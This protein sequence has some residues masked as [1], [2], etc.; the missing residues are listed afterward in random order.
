MK[1]VILVIAFFT[2]LHNLTAQ[3]P[4]YKWAYSIGDVSQEYLNTL[5]VDSENNI[6]IG[7][8]MYSTTDMDPTEFLKILNQIGQKD[9]FIEKFDADGHVLWGLNFG[10]ALYDGVVK[11]VTDDA[12]NIYAVGFYRGVTDLNPDM[13]DQDIAPAHGGYDMFI[14][15]FNKE[16]QF[17]W[18]HGI[19]GLKD[20]FIN[21][22]ALD[23]VGNFYITGQ[24]N[25]TVDFDGTDAGL[26]E[27]N[28]TLDTYDGFLAKYNTDGEIS[29][30]FRIGGLYDDYTNE[31]AI[32]HDGNIIVTGTFEGSVNFGE[33]FL[34]A[35]GGELPGYP[36]EGDAF[37]AKY[38]NSGDL[39]WA[40]S[41]AG[42]TKSN[43]GYDN[44]VTALVLDSEDNI[45][46]TGLIYGQGDFDMDEGQQLVST[47]AD[48]DSYFSKYN[49]EGEYIWAH[50]TAP[51][52]TGYTKD[53]SI[54]GDNNLYLTG[55][56]HYSAGAPFEADFDFNPDSVYAL[57]SYGNHD[58]FV[59]KYAPDAELFWAYNIGGSG[60]DFS[61][62]IA[63][64]QNQNIYAGGW[65]YASDDFDAN[66][67]TNFIWLPYTYPN[68]GDNIWIGKYQPQDVHTA[69]VDISTKNTILLYPNPVRDRLRFKLATFSP[70]ETIKVLSMEGKTIKTFPFS[71]DLDIS[72]LSPGIYLLRIKNSNFKFI[73]E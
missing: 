45:Y 34:E 70:D 51:M 67:D 71:N 68:Y 58:V 7:G 32:D 26:L 43:N 19:G 55:H 46:I 12:N 9:A 64:D 20:D 59:A 39:I 52:V 49:S 42:D 65:F 56:F 23:K 28:S 72:D 3:I 1:K 33:G 18:G 50:V 25:G 4:A 14:S 11:I 17:V 27:I 37:V 61:N 73:K 44:S 2:F 60:Y 36:K 62:A 13:V 21:N 15:K 48:S 8:E 35:S 24:F 66:P 54:D 53:I 5:A 57:Q 47:F 41:I 40:K 63:L 30:A 22:I 10:G 69:T 31:L 38:L 16:G 29:W 6:I